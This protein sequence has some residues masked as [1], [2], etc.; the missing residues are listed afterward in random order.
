MIYL[1]EYFCGGFQFSLPTILA[2]RRFDPI[3]TK[4]S[5]QQKFLFIIK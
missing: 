4:V 3:R 2:K 5:I 1:E